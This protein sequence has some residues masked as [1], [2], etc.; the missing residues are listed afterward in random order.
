MQVTEKSADCFLW[1]PL[2]QTI[3]TNNIGSCPAALGKI[4]PLRSQGVNMRDSQFNIH[5]VIFFF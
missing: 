5:G 1:L 4:G 3:L 2:T